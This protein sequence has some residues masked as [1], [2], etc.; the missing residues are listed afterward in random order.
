MVSTSS[1]HQ[2]PSSAVV[3]L[4]PI[5][6]DTLRAELQGDAFLPGDDGYAGAVFCWGVLIRHEPVIAVMPETAADVAR[7]VAFAA[8]HDLPVAVQGTGHGQPIPCTGGMLINTSRMQG[9][10][11][12]PTSRRAIVEAGV[13]WAK[14]IPLAHEHGLAPLNGSSSDVGVVGYTLG[15]GVGWLAR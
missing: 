4:D 2:G 8:K 11:I 3:T 14:V 7:A 13:K 10:S 9:V 1:S 15:G 12:D 6:V 5:A